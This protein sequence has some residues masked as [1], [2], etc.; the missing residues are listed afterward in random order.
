MLKSKGS[1]L[2]QELFVDKRTPEER[3]KRPPTAS[4]QFRTSVRSLIAVLSECV[5][6]Y[7]RCI[8]PNASKAPLTVDDE[9]FM[10]QVA[11]LGI[12]EGTR[13]KRAGFAYRA[14]YE[15]VLAR[16]R[17]LSKVTWPPAEGAD[18]KAAVTQLLATLHVIPKPAEQ[19]A[20][21]VGMSAVKQPAGI[22]A[23]RGRG[24]GGMAARGRGGRGG[25]NAM[26][27]PGAPGPAGRGA[28]GGTPPPAAAGGTAA[29][30]STPP[31]H[32]AP[33]GAASPA[34]GASGGGV[35]IGSALPGDVG[36]PG[37]FQL[38]DGVDYQLGATKLF[39]KEPRVS[40]DVLR[41]AQCV[42]SIL[43]PS[44]PLCH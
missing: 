36:G 10:N 27:R 38:K 15:D 28:G 4:Q 25:V 42:V 7:V 31:P 44:V 12:V 16:Y 35:N 40:R 33:G 21:G 26:T 24:R 37:T 1:P 9:L 11:Y 23:G 22:G 6:H 3:A 32:A 43:A 5:P 30:T 20:L 29:G 8:K 14:T 39:I 34:P 17:M 2:L 19:G 18:A 13:V 41:E